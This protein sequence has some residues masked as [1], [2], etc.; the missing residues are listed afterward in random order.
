MINDTTVT[1]SP[2]SAWPL[3]VHGDA[4]RQGSFAVRQLGP[5]VPAGPV[6]HTDPLAPLLRA[7][8]EGDAAAVVTGVANLVGCATALLSP[9]RRVVV[10]GEPDGPLPRADGGQRP[11]R[12][13]A[14]GSF[15]AVC[16]LVI[17]SGNH[18][19]GLL[20]FRTPTV[21][22]GLP[23]TMRQAVH[24]IMALLLAARH[25]DER[26]AA[27]E[28][29]VALLSCLSSDE[30]RPDKQAG[31]TSYRAALVTIDAL[32]LEALASQVQEALVGLPLLA[33]G[34]V[35]VLDHRLVC[36]YPDSGT[37]SPRTHATAWDSLVTSLSPSCRVVIGLAQPAGASLR[38][39][40]QR[41][42]RLAEAQVTA[43]VTLRLPRVVMV[44]ELGAVAGAFGPVWGGQLGHFI[45]R[46]VGDLV[47]NPRFRGEMVET[48]H[49]YLV[50][51]S[52]P[53]EAARLMCLSPS[54][55]K[56]RMRVIRK[57]LGDRLDDHD[58]AFEIELALRVLK[59]FDVMQ[60]LA[61]SPGLAPCGP[62]GRR[63][64]AAAATDSET[65]SAR[66]GRAPVVS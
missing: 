35:A 52:S 11:H 53:T 49:A 1:M 8:A 4:G 64:Q 34:R 32:P 25:A 7:A 45:Q 37:E 14:V 12:W 58:A 2:P 42:R 22:G 18:R 28:Q 23:P 27:A 10:I 65:G 21:A 40:Y 56:Y 44:D 43:V 38:Q 62:I 16:E 50:S 55:M 46:V 17:H 66:A 59:A 13:A 48:L 61:T 5:Q 36:L 33:A 30:A 51:G 31:A 29:R 54:T 26:V 20:A 6:E 24:D 41:A 57:I 63:S 60:D 39:E 15:P 47:D 9:N 19:L 3:A